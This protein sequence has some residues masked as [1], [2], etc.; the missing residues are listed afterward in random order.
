MLHDDYFV[1]VDAEDDLAFEPAFK[2]LEASPTGILTQY[3]FKNSA[4]P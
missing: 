4:K 1:Y 2:V 3:S